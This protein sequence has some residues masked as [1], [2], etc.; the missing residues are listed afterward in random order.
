MALGLVKPVTGGL[1]DNF[2]SHTGHVVVSNV[3]ELFQRRGVTK[4][5]EMEAE[6]LSQHLERKK[7]ERSAIGEL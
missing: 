1:A 2:L 4:V 3:D 7:R 5:S 6:A